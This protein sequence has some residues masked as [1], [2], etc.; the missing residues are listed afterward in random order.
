MLVPLLDRRHAHGPVLRAVLA[1]LVL[2]AAGLA[3]AAPARADDTVG[4]AGAPSNGTDP[5]GRSRYSYQVQPGQQVADFYL[6][7]NTGTTDQS[8]ELVATD[9]YNTDDGAFALLA[10][11]EEPKDA[12]A[13]VTLQDG[14]KRLTVPLA[15]GAQ[16]VVPFTVTVPADARP[17]DH[18]AGL[19]VSASAVE[20]QVKVE[21]RV[22][23]RMY[24]R[25]AGELQPVLTV[26]SI[27]ASAPAGANPLTGPSTVTVTV[28]NTGNVALGATLAAGATTWFGVS[29]ARAVHEEVPEILPGATRVVTLSVPGV[30][31]S[32]LLRPYVDLQ[33]NVDPAAL[34]PGP[35]APVHRDTTVVAVPWMLLGILALAV[36]GWFALRARRR[37]ETRRAQEWIAFTQE[38]ARRAAALDVAR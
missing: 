38:E 33:P 28:H 26:A 12:G 3:V 19:V 36:G 24:V 34:D 4:I 23:T 30:G 21:R 10:T 8:V 13:W 17:G 16:Q 2:V 18:A 7:R 9:A 27:T 22:A 35:L 1:L 25:V 29:A 14:Q 11:D 20:G 6:V 31:R 37:R 5:D 32:G 15:P